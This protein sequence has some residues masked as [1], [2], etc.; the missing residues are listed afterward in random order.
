MNDAEKHIDKKIR[1][2]VGELRKAEL[3]SVQVDNE[4][5]H[6]FNYTYEMGDKKTQ[7]VSGKLQGDSIEFKTS[8]GLTVAFT[9]KKGDK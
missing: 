3:T 5:A 1:S 8:N 7:T 4:K 9:E 6:H 2:F